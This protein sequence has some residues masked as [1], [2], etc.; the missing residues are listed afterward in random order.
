MHRP[1]A[2][3]DDQIQL[4]RP[5]GRDG[6]GWR[7]APVEINARDPAEELGKRLAARLFYSHSPEGYVS[8][9]SDL[10]VD[11]DC[12]T[13]LTGPKG[14][15]GRKAGLAAGNPPVDFQVPIGSSVQPLAG[16]IRDFDD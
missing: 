16:L 5:F 11:D 9:V 7:T 2:E 13:E 8:P 4:N 1:R 14:D 10:I 15:S 6:N 12:H 3:L